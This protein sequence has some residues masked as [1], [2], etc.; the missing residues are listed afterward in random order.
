MAERPDGRFARA[1]QMFWA[2]ARGPPPAG[3]TL[4]HERA[5]EPGATG[6]GCINEEQLCGLRWH[7]TYAL[8]KV[9]QAG[10]QS[11]ERGHLRTRVWRSIGDSHRLLVD[12]HADAEGA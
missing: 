9:T 7:L 2:S 11:A 6:A 8:L 1:H 5:R 4:R 10:A 3:I 12:L